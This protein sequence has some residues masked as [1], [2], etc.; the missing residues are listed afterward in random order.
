MML[1]AN[2]VRLVIKH[3]EFD[4]LDKAHNARLND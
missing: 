4:S 2:H 1:R 3:R